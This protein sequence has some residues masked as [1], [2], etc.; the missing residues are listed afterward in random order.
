[1]VSAIS[2]QMQSGEWQRLV[3]G[4]NDGLGVQRV[5]QSPCSWD[6]AACRRGTLA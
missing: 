5:A 6:S 1:L 3:R 4:V 2:R